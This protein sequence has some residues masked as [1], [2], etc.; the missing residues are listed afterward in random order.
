MYSKSATI[1]TYNVLLVSEYIR[2]R[3]HQNKDSAGKK[4]EKVKENTWW[5]TVPEEAILPARRG[6][7]VSNG[8]LTARSRA[9]E[10]PACAKME[11]ELLRTEKRAGDLP[12]T[13]YNEPYCSGCDN[14]GW[15]E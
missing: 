10:T 3:K 8:S 6:Q 12:A 13:L 15:S 1:A 4:Y 14:E 5:I 2:I 11:M 9:K 7:T